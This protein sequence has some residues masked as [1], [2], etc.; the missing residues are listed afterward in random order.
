[1]DTFP[2]FVHVYLKVTPLYLLNYVKLISAN[3]LVP[4]QLEEGTQAS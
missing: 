4:R 2:Y 3:I 1:M